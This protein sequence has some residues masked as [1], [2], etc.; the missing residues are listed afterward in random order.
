[1]CQKN[2]RMKNV[3]RVFLAKC[4]TFQLQFVFVR[5]LFYSSIE[6]FSFLLCSNQVQLPKHLHEN[7]FN[8]SSVNSIQVFFA[9]INLEQLVFERR[10][11]NKA[12]RNSAKKSSAGFS[13]LGHSISQSEKS[14]WTCVRMMK[15]INIKVKTRFCE[16]LIIAVFFRGQK[17]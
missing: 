16:R 4:K 13:K 5:R 8:L 14:F 2:F 9:A 6:K 17:C 7:R 12:G 10:S 1:M 11:R 3:F 15:Q